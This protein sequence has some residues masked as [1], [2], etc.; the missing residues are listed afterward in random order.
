[1]Y[2]CVCGQ[3]RLDDVIVSIPNGMKERCY[4]LSVSLIRVRACS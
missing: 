2:I 4:A 1:M 3:K